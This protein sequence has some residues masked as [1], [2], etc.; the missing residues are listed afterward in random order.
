MRKLMIIAGLPLGITT[1]GVLA[2]SPTT[3]AAD[4]HAS[5]SA[6]SSHQTSHIMG[7]DG[8]DDETST[9]R[10]SSGGGGGGGGGSLPATGID[11]TSLALLG[12][13]TIAAGGAT[14]RLSLRRAS[15]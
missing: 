4:L 15:R 6:V 2:G 5:S 10:S 11:A 3:S 13:L 9:R 8:D 1:I 7:E 12:A 14:Y